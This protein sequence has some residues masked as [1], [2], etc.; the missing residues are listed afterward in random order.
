MIKG[1]TVEEVEGGHLAD[2]SMTLRRTDDPGAP[3]TR[4]GA[5]VR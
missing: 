1:Q 4:C 2:P 5:E 3:P